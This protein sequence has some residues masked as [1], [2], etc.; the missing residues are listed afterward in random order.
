MSSHL[1]RS[2]LVP[3]VT[4]YVLLMVILAAGLRVQRRRAAAGLLQG[5]AAS[6]GRRD[7][8]WQALI[9]HVGADVIGGYLLLVAVVVAYYYG[10]A[11]VGSN[12][13]ASAFTGSALL[14]A[15]S[16]PV[17]A[18]ASWLTW[19]RGSRPGHRRRPAPPAGPAGP[20]GGAGATP[21]GP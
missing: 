11:K 14:L 13:L 10:V 9:V 12:F 16:L 4:G 6:A 19:R 1:I 17:S 21:C 2:D 7:H 3:I 8:G 15:I 20:A 5:R 18:V